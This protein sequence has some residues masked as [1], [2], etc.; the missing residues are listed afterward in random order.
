MAWA[1]VPSRG[2]ATRPDPERTSYQSFCSF[3]DP[4][5]NTAR[6]HEVP[7]LP[8]R[9]YGRRSPAATI[10]RLSIVLNGQAVLTLV[11]H[12]RSCG[13][14]TSGELFPLTSGDGQRLDPRA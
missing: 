12:A 7:D 11:Y 10:A 8:T 14:L 2:S 4:D 13:S 9:R 1:A 3:G 6:A 5:G